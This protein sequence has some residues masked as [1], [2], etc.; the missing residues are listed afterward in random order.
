MAVTTTNLIQGPADIYAGAF[1]ATEPADTSFASVPD[2]G[3]WTDLGGT[4]GGIT[5]SVNQEYAELEV[6]QLVDTPER[7]MTKR[8]FTIATSLA[9]GT[10][11]NLALALNAL[12]TESTGGSAETAY[13]SLTAATGSSATQPTYAALLVDGYAPESNRRRFI[14]RKMLQTGNVSLGYSKGDKTVIP[15]SFV[16]HYVSPS[17]APFKSVD[18]D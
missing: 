1:G 3:S 8:E 5:L 16:G 11:A 4:D 10:L 9:E 12:V 17:I 2:S 15:V 6:D 7:R 13:T 14:G 18:Q